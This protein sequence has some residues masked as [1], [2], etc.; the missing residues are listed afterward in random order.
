MENSKFNELK[1]TN[2]LYNI[3]CGVI[4]VML[5]AMSLRRLV[6]QILNG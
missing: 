3:V 6:T 5:Y 2:D 4:Y 1:Q